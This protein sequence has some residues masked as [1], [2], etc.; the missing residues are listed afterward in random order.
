MFNSTIHPD[1]TDAMCCICRIDF[2][3]GENLFVS[4]CFHMFHENCFNNYLNVS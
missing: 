2:L 3:E 4:H 1:Y